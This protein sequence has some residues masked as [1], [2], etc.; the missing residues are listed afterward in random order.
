MNCPSSGN[1][2]HMC[3]TDMTFES[4]LHWVLHVF[5]CVSRQIC[6][7]KTINQAMTTFFQIFINWPI[8]DHLC[9]SLNITKFTQLNVLFCSLFNNAVSNSGHTVLNYWMMLVKGQYTFRKGISNEDAVFKLKD[10]EFK[11]INQNMCVEEISCDLAEVLDCMNYE[12][13]LTKLHL[14]GIWG[15]SEDWFRS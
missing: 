5:F 11:S 8:T 3:L 12:I 13:L 1:F 15:I 4:R 14:Y 9:I 6:R 7:I 10:T 2:L